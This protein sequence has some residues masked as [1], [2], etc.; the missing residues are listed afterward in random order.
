MIGAG[1]IVV[2]DICI[3]G[4]YMGVFAKNRTNILGRVE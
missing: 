3:E 4:T 1:A 2:K